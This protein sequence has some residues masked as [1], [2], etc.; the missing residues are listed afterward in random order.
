MRRN[1]FCEKNVPGKRKENQKVKLKISKIIFKG[2]TKYHKVFI[3]TNPIYGKILTLDG[4]VEFS[5]SDEFIYHE[6]LVHPL[7]FSLK[8]KEKILII[9]G[10]DGGVLREVLKHP[11]KSVELVEMDPEIIEISKKYLKFVSK[12]SFSDKRL[13]IFEGKGEDFIRHTKSTYDGIIV[14]STGPNKYG[15]PLLSK[16][17][18][19]YASRALN[20]NGILSTLVS[21]FLDFKEIIKPTYRNAK[22]FFKYVGIMRVTIPSYNCGEFC[23]MIMSN[24]VNVEKPRIRI[25][26]KKFKRFIKRHTLRF[27]TPEIHEA[28]MVLPPIWRV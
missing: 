6:M 11:V 16:K 21:S 13:K 26:N 19:K 22:K 18:Y 20:K 3:F 4:I 10:G 5:E 15:L 17:F 24:S 23:F 2:R 7:M 12:N 9:G 27:Y 1:W 14:D 25:L 28:S 8:R